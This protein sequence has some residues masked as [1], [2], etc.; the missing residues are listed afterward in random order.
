MRVELEPRCYGRVR[1][2]QAHGEAGDNQRGLDLLAQTRIDVEPLGKRRTW[3]LKDIAMAQS[4]LGDR[5]AAR[6]TIKALDLAI[7]SPED[8]QKG[9]WNTNLSAVAEAQLAVGDVEEAF[10]T[11]IPISSGEGA[12]RDMSKRLKDQ[13]SMLTKLA[14]AAADDNH[15]SR[16]G[17]DPARPMTTPEKA[18]RLAIVRRAVKAAEAMSDASENRVAWATALGQLGAFDEA[19]LVARRV[20][21]ERIQ[22]PGQCDA[23]W[24]LWRISF[25]QAKAASHGGTVPARHD[26]CQGRRLDIGR[27][28]LR[29][30]L[31]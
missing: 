17:G 15:Q 20:D 5:D 21:Q 28:D 31:A 22:Q 6:E 16:H 10:R 7:I 8:R 11:C 18:T 13:A 25:S 3:L 19:V 23:I 4:E 29:R 27:A 2:A 24:A 30:H 14:S 1:I 26:P 12:K 9:R